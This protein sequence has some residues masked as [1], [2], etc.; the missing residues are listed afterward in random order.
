MSHEH[1]I[2]KT[3]IHFIEFDDVLF[4][5]LDDLTYFGEGN[6]QNRKMD[7]NFEYCIDCDLRLLDGKPIITKGIFDDEFETLVNDTKTG[8]AI[9]TKEITVQH[10]DYETLE[11]LIKNMLTLS[12]LK[13][14]TSK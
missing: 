14:K 6:S 11:R 3:Q 2:K 12:E 4:N 13:R 7:F 9:K 5:K 10:S 1:V 8:N